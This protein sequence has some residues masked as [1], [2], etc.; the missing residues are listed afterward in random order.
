[1]EPYIELRVF[2]FVNILYTTLLDKK[3]MQKNVN[4]QLSG[5]V[6]TRRGE[7]HIILTNLKIHLNYT[8]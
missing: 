7:L 1:M 8:H 3:K 2:S 4:V 5:L 6:H